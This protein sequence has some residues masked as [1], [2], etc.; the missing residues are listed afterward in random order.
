LEDAKITAQEA[1]AAY[2]ELVKSEEWTNMTEDDR[3]HA[4]QVMLNTH[5]G[6]MP[7][8]LHYAIAALQVRMFSH[9][10]FI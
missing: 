2:D 3:L 10:V 1:Q 6:V 8:R 5:R 7:K 4:S 9:L